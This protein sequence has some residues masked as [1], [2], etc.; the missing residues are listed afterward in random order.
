MNYHIIYHITHKQHL[1]NIL[2][3]GC[4]KSP[5]GHIYACPT[6]ED[7]LKFIAFSERWTLGDC[8]VLE[9]YLPT[10]LPKRWEESLDHNKKYIPADAIVYR[11][12]ELP[13]VNFNVIDFDWDKILA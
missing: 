7:S 12:T 5:W 11:H 10:N 6:Y 3:E 1:S 2:S 9:L 8:I 13:F 4:L